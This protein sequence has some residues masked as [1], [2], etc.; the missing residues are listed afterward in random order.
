MTLPIRAALADPVPAC[1]IPSATPKRLASALLAVLCLFFASPADLHA[2]PGANWPSFRGRAA[3]GVA[4][5]F[6]TPQRWS[7]PEGQNIQWKVPV[8]G[9]GHACPIVWEDRVFIATAV[10][11]GDDEPLKPGI[12]GNIEPVEDATNTRWVLCCFDRNTGEKRW[13]RTAHT[14]VPTIKRHPKSSHANS[15]P[16]TDGRRVVAFFGSEGIYCYDLEGQL[17]WKRQIGVLDS[18]YYRVPTAQWGFGSSP[19]IHGDRVFIQCDVQKDSFVAALNLE[20]GSEVW[21]TPRDDVPTWSTPIVHVGP[22]RSQVILNG[23]KHMGGY[24]AATGEELWRLAGGGDIPVPTPIFSDDL[25]Y[26]TS[27]HGRPAPIYAVRLDATGDITPGEAAG[28]HVAWSHSKGGN[29][30]QTPLLYGEHL[31]L[32]TDGGVASCLIARTGERVYRQRLDVRAGYTASPVAADEKIYFTAETGDVVVLE[33]GP[34]PK[35]LAI[36]PLGETCLSTPAIAR[37]TLFFRTR[38]HL[39]AVSRQERIPK[40]RRVRQFWRTD[41]AAS[42]TE[43]LQDAGETFGP[44]R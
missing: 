36:N 35:V 40:V 2:D 43:G 44:G 24:D 13:Q 3:C 21:R 7:V 14:G 32:C 33:A 29:Y 11:D 39:V 9:L 16:A 18:G 25:V 38:H 5:G 20:D 28:Q 42:S 8:P 23:Y 41:P 17:L 15:T 34:E 37:G 26:L 27:A 6:K 30:M 4:D 19:L 10:R 1:S 12:Y 22:D 31:Y